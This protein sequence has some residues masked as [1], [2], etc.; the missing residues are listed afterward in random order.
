M[1]SSVV[2]LEALKSYYKV[3]RKLGHV[4][5]IDVYRLVL[6]TFISDLR[7]EE[8]SWY[9][10]DE[11]YEYLLYVLKCLS[12]Q[13][14]FI[15]YNPECLKTDTVKNFV[16]D[17]PIKITESEVIRFSMNDILKLSNR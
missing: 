5:D 17:T 1:N 2:I 3:L 7:K 16:E 4:I 6:I 11:D 12:K 13:S 9:I 8:Y 15:P 14:C 10:T